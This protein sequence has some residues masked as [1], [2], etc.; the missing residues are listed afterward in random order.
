MKTLLLLLS[1]SLTVLAADFEFDKQKGMAVPNYIGQVKL[2]KGK[3]FKIAQG[4]KQ[5]I[6]VGA[7]FH[8]NDT[9]ITLAQSFVKFQVVDDTIM[10]I[11]PN[12]EL[13][14]AEFDFTTKTERKA[15]YSF[16]RGQLSGHVKSKAKEGD[17]VVKTK[18]AAMAIRGTEI[19]VNHQTQ[20]GI[21]IS[22]FALLSGSALVSDD[23]DKKHDL[24][25]SDRVV[26]A[27]DPTSDQTA[28]LKLQLSTEEMDH[29]K[30]SDKNEETEFK[31]FMPFIEPTKISLLN[32]VSP[33]E[34]HVTNPSTSKELQG[35]GTL[36]NLRKLNE[37]LRQNQ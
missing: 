29:L 2:L 4:Q 18:F 5:E 13:N 20:K 23:K 16:V 14:F 22:E 3:A 37:K 33:S 12:S 32:Q 31:P 34:T 19:L 9:L 36:H 30:A 8:K 21:E 11:G 24:F 27:H 35:K 17:V 15:V 25:R 28:D 7:R 10:S 1:L 26:I 6:K